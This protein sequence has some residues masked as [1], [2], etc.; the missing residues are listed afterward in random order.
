[1]NKK[2]QLKKGNKM[3]K[4]AMVIGILS[5]LATSAQAGGYVCKPNIYGGTTCVYQSWVF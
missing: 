1:M 5:V 4:I 3:K 2:N